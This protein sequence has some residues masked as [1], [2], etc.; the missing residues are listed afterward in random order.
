MDFELP[1]EIR[2]LKD[3]VRRF[4]DQELIPIEMQLDGWP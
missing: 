3:T 2:I 4:V 1:D